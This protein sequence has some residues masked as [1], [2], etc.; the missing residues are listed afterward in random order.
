MLLVFHVRLTLL[1]NMGPRV[2]FVAVLHDS[3]VQSG[4]VEICAF[5]L[6]RETKHLRPL[7]GEYLSVDTRL[8][9]LMISGLPCYRTFLLINYCVQLAPSP[10][11]EP[12][13]RLLPEHP[14]H[15]PNALIVYRPRAHRVSYHLFECS[16]R[17]QHVHK[18]GIVRKRERV[19]PMVA[20]SPGC[21]TESTCSL[22][23]A[24][25]QYLHRKLKSFKKKKEKKKFHQRLSRSCLQ[26][27]DFELLLH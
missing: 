8:W 13:I 25:V 3:S 18:A 26:G 23:Q 24:V 4:S 22:Y 19:W 27:R 17:W 20:L 6:R 2:H 15:S 7:S 14:V 9:S 10:A 12:D 1:V 21:R 16:A 11:A 5:L